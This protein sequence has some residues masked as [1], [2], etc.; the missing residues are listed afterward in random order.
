MRIEGDMFG[1]LDVAIS[2][3]KASRKHMDVVTS[4]VVNAQTTDDG[5]GEPYRRL[6]AIFKASSEKGISGV[7]VSDVSQDMTEFPKVLNPGHPQADAQ[8]YVR[9]P[10][11]NLP[12]ELIQMNQATRAYEANAALLRRYQRMVEASLALLR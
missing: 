2:G 3:L 7:E 4:N 5:K 1:T 10:N 11:V 8:G 6:E 12:R 9:M